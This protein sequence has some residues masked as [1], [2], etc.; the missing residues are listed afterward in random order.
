MLDYLGYG[1][2]TDLMAAAIPDVIKFEGGHSLPEPKSEADAIAR[3]REIA[4]KNRVT[5]SYLGLGYYGT[6]T[7]GV[8]QR[9]ILEDPS[10][11]TAYTP[12]Q[13]EISQGRLEALINFQTMVTDLT[14]MHTAN[15]SMLDEGTAAVEAMMIAKR[16]AG[17]ASHVFYVDTDALPQTKSLLE[18]RAEPLGIE[19][20]Y[21][22]AAAGAGALEGEYF[23]VLVQYPGA[24]GR[25]VDP[26]GI[27]E[28]AHAAGALAVAVADLL[29][30]TLLA[31]PGEAG[32]DVVAG[33]TQ[34]FGVP[35]GYGG[36]HAGYLAVREGLERT[37]PGRLVGVS[38]DADGL[39]A[40]RLTLQTREQH[41]RREKATSNIC[42][43]QALNAL[44]GVV[45]LAW[46]GRQGFVQLGE[47]LL[48]RT[49]YAR[50]AL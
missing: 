30:L 31:P 12:Y 36:P 7:P 27:F 13:P 40:Y 18:H 8:I 35:M 15:A 22:D 47:L 14:G 1:S 24:S 50:E 5:R 37:M 43:A 23:G 11:Y 38:V 29:S 49:H 39:P 16:S 3:L 46:L 21:F 25:L 28:A 44:A 2:L 33:T 48:R 42:T 32:A 34:R 9:N 20:R 10:W 41:I 4:A 6:F 45:Y 19:I 26:A 17:S